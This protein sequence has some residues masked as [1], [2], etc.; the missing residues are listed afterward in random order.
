MKHEHLVPISED[1]LLDGNKYIIFD[2]SD[3]PHDLAGGPFLL[4]A[5]FKTI[6]N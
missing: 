2:D 5:L 1:D 3:V 6:F 4:V